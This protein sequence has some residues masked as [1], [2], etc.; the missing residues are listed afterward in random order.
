M[1]NGACVQNGSHE[2]DGDDDRGSGTSVWRHL[3]RR[4]P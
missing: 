1:W 4:G 3:P 2:G